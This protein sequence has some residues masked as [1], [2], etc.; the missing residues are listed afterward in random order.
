MRI[1]IN[2]YPSFSHQIPLHELL[3]LKASN[4]KSAIFHIFKDLTSQN[5]LDF[6]NSNNKKQ[7]NDLPSNS[8]PQHS[9]YQILTYIQMS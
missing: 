5:G 9:I 3:H 8:Q 1:K 7:L 6:S 4:V 2:S